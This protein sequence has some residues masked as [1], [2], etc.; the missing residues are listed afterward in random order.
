MFGGFLLLGGRASDL[1]GRQRLFI[2][3]VIVFTCASLVNGVAT[4]ANVLIAGRALAGSRWRARLP[5][6]ALDRH[7][8]LRRRTGAHEGARCLERDRRGRCSRG[9]RDRRFPHRVPDL[10]LGLLRQP[11]DRR[12]RRTALAA[13]R[14]ELARRGAARDIRRGGSRDRHRR[15]A[16]ARVRDREGTDLRL[17]LGEDARPLPPRGD[18]AGGVRRRRA[19]VTRAA[20]P[21]GDLP[22][23]LAERQQRCDAPRRL[24]S[25]RDVLLR[26]A[27]PA[28][29]PRLRAVEGRARI[30]AVHARDHR[31]CR[32]LAGA[33]LTDRHPRGDVHRHHDGNGR[34]CSTSRA[35]R[36]TAPT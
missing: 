17:G 7:D 26:V 10:A 34:V 11:A 15:A 16:R 18:P 31:R 1:L 5:R 35:S 19:S 27:L 2:A 13:L 4:S 14:A 29:D 36:R 28:A 25:L 8:H 3:G 24:G 6:G 20:H 22:H 33:D 12:R 32:C 23:A 21:P 9:P 30:R